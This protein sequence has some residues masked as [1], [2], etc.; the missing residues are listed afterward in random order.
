MDERLIRTDADKALATMQSIELV[1]LQELDRICRKHNIKYS[2]GGG[3][4]L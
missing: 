4:C 1:G 3:T 2:L